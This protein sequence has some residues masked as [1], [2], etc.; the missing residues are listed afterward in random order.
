MEPYYIIIFAHIS[1]ERYHQTLVPIFLWSGWNFLILLEYWLSSY[2]NYWSHNMLSFLPLWDWTLI[3]LVK[4]PALPCS[5]CTRIARWH[6]FVFC[7]FV[8]SLYLNS[9]TGI[10]ARSKIFPE[11]KRGKGE[12]GLKL[13]HVFISPEKFSD[14]SPRP[15]PQKGS[16]L[17]R[18]FRGLFYPLNLP[19]C[20]KKKKKGGGR[21]AMA[22]SALISNQNEFES[23]QSL[24]NN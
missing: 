19:I 10:S 21:V 23:K 13:F 2:V 8:T 5:T 4:A 16:S 20:K 9:N 1:L 17:L 12:D 6:K 3:E 11:K 22:D 18:I 24:M 15:L 7:T 14:K